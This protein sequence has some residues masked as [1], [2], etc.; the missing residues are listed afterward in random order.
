MEFAGKESYPKIL[1]RKAIFSHL[2]FKRLLRVPKR[3]RLRKVGMGMRCRVGSQEWRLGGQFGAAVTSRQEAWCW[4][5]SL[6]EVV[7]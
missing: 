6:W 4:P 1:S 5:R 3:E 7:G 2:L